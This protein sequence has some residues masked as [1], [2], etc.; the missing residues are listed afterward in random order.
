MKLQEVIN[1]AK[2]MKSYLVTVTIRN[3][4]RDENNLE[5][6][7]I[8]EDFPNDD[9]VESLDHCV[10]SMGIKP[11]PP[12]DIIIPEPL[13]EVRRPLKIAIISHF[14]AMPESYSP[15]RAVR[16][17]VKILLEHGHEVVFF[18][19][20]GS[21]IDLGCEMRPV[22]PKFK[23]EKGIVN[24]EMK[25]KFIDVLRE[26]LTIDFDIAITHDFFIQDCITYREAIRD[27]GVKKEWLHFARSGVAE[28]INWDMPNARYVYLNK[29]DTVHFAKHVG[30]TID[31]IRSIYNEKEPAYMLRWHPVTR[32]I[33]DKYRLWERDI[34]QT[35]PICTTRMGAKGLD[36]VIKIFVEL[37]RLG[38]KV[39][40]IVCNANGKRRSEDLKQKIAWAKEVGLAD[41][42]IIFT[43][44]LADDTYKIASEVP[45][46]VAAELMG[47]SN[48]FIFPTRAENGPN[49]LLEASLTK[50][51]IVI[52]SDLPL[53]YDFVGDNSVLEYG[54]TSNRNLH[55]KGREIDTIQVLA[56]MIIGQLKSNKPD[57]QFRH[58]WKNHNA[59]S[60]YYNMLEPVLYEKISK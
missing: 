49:V 45:N 30:T 17:Q 50:N 2:E 5:H 13:R 9:I 48:L 36:D 24:E 6:H 31:K 8:R 15:A 44:L 19:Q 57:L 38:E 55:Y 11:E 32:M 58:V 26:Q 3:K 52:N 22:V 59:N 18:T 10:R 25:K 43:S 21:E 7:C 28:F 39:C 4:D 20:E 1:K 46:Q 29:S 53:L 42:E 12:A 51:L 37:K 60:I 47:I 34:I 16:N 23:R 56:K 27:C 35:Y 40:L 33:V 14:N 41:D 54:F